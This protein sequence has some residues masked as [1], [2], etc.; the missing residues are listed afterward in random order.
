MKTQKIQKAS[1]YH[2]GKRLDLEIEHHKTVTKVYIIDMSKYWS[3]IDTVRYKR[4][5]KGNIE[6]DTRD[7]CIAKGYFN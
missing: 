2:N 4:P 6:F 5:Y 1:I 3:H 7:Y